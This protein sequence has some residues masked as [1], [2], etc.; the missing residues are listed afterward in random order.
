MSVLVTAHSPVMAAERLYVRYSIF[1]RSLSIADLQ[2]YVKHG[3]RSP[4]LDAYL[5]FLRPTQQ[6]QLRSLLQ[7][8]LQLE[9][10]SVA[11]FLYSP[12][13]ERLLQRLAQ[14]IRPTNRVSFYGLRSALILAADDPDG[15]TLMSLL[16]HYPGSTLRVDLVKGLEIFASI[17]R[18]VTQSNQALMAVQ[19]QSEAETAQAP[20]HLPSQ[21][22]ELQDSGP[23]NWDKI[24]LK[25]TDSSPQR[26]DLTGAARNFAAE[27]YLPRLPQIQ[28]QPVVVISHGLGSNLQSYAYLA[29]HLTS[30]GFVVAV[31]EHPG[32]STDQLVAWLKGAGKLPIQPAEFIDR[33]LDIK[34]LLDELERRSQTD[35][36]FRDRLNL[37]QVGLI[38]QSFGGYTVL[39]LAGAKIDLA[40]LHQACNAQLDTSLNLALLFQCQSLELP[41]RDY[42]FFD[43]RIK[44]VIAVNPIISGMFGPASLAKV[45]LPVMV[46]SGSAD[47]FAPPLPEQIQP[48]T[49]LTSP[50]RYLVTMDRA[51]HFSTL[52]E[53]PPNSTVLPVPSGLIGPQPSLARRYLDALSTA[54]F[55]TYLGADRPSASLL[56]PAAVHAISQAPVPVN[57]SRQFTAAELRTALQAP[58]PPPLPEKSSGRSPIYPRAVFV[59]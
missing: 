42:D 13:G 18:V 46:I 6:Q 56:T 5:R 41:Q 14:V 31:L 54:F 28:P 38:G 53:A 19:T 49:W 29:E 37:Q 17:Q 4:Q 35:P 51:T 3:Q 21:L 48:F 2:A 11:Q 27:I 30:F 24:S 36:T 1:E 58:S 45:K 44:A 59:P 33:P 7:E 16:R 39:T 32:S 9:P 12:I 47:T 26:L 22:S 52:G 20:I 25:L 34:F 50:Q 57:L 23:Y 55:Q 15:L 8:R 40:H 10:V 43:P